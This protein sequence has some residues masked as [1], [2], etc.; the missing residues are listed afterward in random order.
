MYLEIFTTNH[1]ICVSFPIH[2]GYLTSKLAMAADQGTLELQ[3]AAMSRISAP[4]EVSE[5]FE[6]CVVTLESINLIMATETKHVLTHQELCLPKVR[7]QVLVAL[8]NFEVRGVVHCPELRRPTLQA[9]AS[10]NI[11][12]YL[13]LLDGTAVCLKT[14][15]IYKGKVFLVPKRQ[16]ELLSILAP[17]TSPLSP[18]PNGHSNPSKSVSRLYR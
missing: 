11:Q 9:L 2:S 13:T 5:R 10:R 8:G 17:A 7:L 3:T 6:T 4:G 14:D 16:I 18:H 1:R 12:N 15:T